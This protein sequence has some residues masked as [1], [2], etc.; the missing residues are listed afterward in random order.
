M[1]ILYQG[2]P[3]MTSKNIMDSIVVPIGEYTFSQIL[4]KK[5]YFLPRQGKR[6]I[7]MKYIFFYRVKPIQAITHYGIIEKYIDDADGMLNIIE[8]MKSFSDP[9]KSAS[10]YKFSKV[11]ELEN[12]IPLDRECNSIQGRISGTFE[13]ISKLKTTKGLFKTK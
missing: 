11:Q 7:D 3:N 8:K 9:A 6:N 13:K 1:L 2:V 4:T 12:P 5:T 10:A